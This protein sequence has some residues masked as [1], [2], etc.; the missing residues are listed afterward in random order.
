M[1]D[2]L[3]QLKRDRYSNAEIS[4]KLTPK[5]DDTKSSLSG[6]SSTDARRLVVITS[7]NSASYQIEHILWDETPST[8]KFEWKERDETGRTRKSTVTVAEYL[9]KRWKVKLRVEELNQ[10]LLMLSQRGQEVYLVP[11]RCHEA[12]LPANFT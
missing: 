2:V 3:T 12:S 9:E 4:E 10:P 11:S 5:W 6:Q 8:K 7:Y 1:L